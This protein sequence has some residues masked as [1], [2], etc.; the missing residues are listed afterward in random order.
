M[1]S[2]INI[3][4]ESL[5]KEEV[6]VSKDNEKKVEKDAPKKLLNEGDDNVL[7]AALQRIADMK[8]STYDWE[9]DEM[10]SDARTWA[11]EAL[12]A[13]I[14]FNPPKLDINLRPTNFDD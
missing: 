7:F 2:F 6:L 10:M 9:Y 13:Y 11:R 8:D 14:E 5:A 12:H 3:I 4:N 1:R